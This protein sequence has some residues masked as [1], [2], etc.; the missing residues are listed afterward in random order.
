M[1]PEVMRGYGYGTE[2]DIWSLG[3]LHFEFVCGYLPFADTLEDPTE[4]VSESD[5]N[6]CQCSSWGVSLECWRQWCR[7][8]HVMRSIRVCERLPRRSKGCVWNCVGDDFDLA[9]SVQVF[10]FQSRGSHTFRTEKLLT[11]P[12]ASLLPRRGV[13]HFLTLCHLHVR[14][15]PLRSLAETCRQCRGQSWKNTPC[16]GDAC[17]HQC[18]ATFSNPRFDEIPEDNPEDE[19]E[20]G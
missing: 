9:F 1:A 4:V 10:S 2:V 8:Y 11:Q 20:L 19:L 5:R 3:V 15:V 13:Q 16:R 12:S 18:P 14:E 6:M 7:V 17:V